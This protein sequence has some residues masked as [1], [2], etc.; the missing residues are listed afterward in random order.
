M[1]ALL[2][3]LS[4]RL[5]MLVFGLLGVAL[6]RR[7]ERADPLAFI[8]NDSF[9]SEDERTRSVFLLDW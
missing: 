6:E 1:W 8:S 5:R 7:E 4:F 9:K 2:L 3:L